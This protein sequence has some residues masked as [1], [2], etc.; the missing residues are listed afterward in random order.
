MDFWSFGFFIL[1]LVCLFM[2]SQCKYSKS[3]FG[4][5]SKLLREKLAY[6]KGI[7]HDLDEHAM[8][9]L[10]EDYYLPVFYFLKNLA[11]RKSIDGSIRPL[12]VGLSA[13]QGCG[14][15]TV[16]K[17]DHIVPISQKF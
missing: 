4:A 5:H 16:S 15:T 10:V 3:A 7:H 14:K 1:S 6:G 9:G 13:P 2:D 17:C 12:L 11:R 8:S